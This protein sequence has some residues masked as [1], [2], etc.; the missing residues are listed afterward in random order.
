MGAEARRAEQAARGGE[1]GEDELQQRL[2]ATR[3]VAALFGREST[4]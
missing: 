4:T 1:I 3:E 2:N